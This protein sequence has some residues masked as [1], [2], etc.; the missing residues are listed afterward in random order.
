MTHITARMNKTHRSGTDAECMFIRQIR[1]RLIALM[2][3]EKGSSLV[4]II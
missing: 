3:G 4:L 2:T 1:N